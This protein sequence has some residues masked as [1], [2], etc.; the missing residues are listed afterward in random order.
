MS[1]LLVESTTLP[2]ATGTPGRWRATFLTPGQ[3]SSG[4]YDSEMI[5]EHGPKAIRKGA[6][7]FVTHNRLPNGEPDPFAMWGFIAED[8]I[9]SES[10][11]LSGE[12][13]VLPSWREKVEEVA[14]HTALSVYVMGDVD[15]DGNVTALHEDAQNGVDLVVYPG[16]PGSGLVEKLYESMKASAAPVAENGSPTGAA[17]VTERENKMDEAKIQALFEAALKPVSDKL[18][19][20]ETTLNA[21]KTLSESAAAERTQI[22]DAFEV[23]DEVSK[24]VLE[25]KLPEEGRQRVIEAVKTGKA[26]PEAVKSET[27]YIE[28]IRKVEEPSAPLV[29]GRVNTTDPANKGGFKLSN[30]GEVA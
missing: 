15:E 24:A 7:C 8:P 12:I 11:A 28:A 10:G 5:R 27:D 20:L 14:P 18:V 21:V 17:D 26:V 23:A 19:E 9:V 1:T 3:G 30:L 22:E 25:A 29:E 6:K 2:V 4:K 13:E 16:R